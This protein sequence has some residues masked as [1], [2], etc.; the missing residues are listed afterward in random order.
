MPHAKV[1]GTRLYQQAGTGEPLILIRGLGLDHTYY[2]QG[3]PRMS[4][5]TADDHGRPALRR[6]VLHR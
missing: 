5:I 2:A 4:P 6:P 1:N 3:V